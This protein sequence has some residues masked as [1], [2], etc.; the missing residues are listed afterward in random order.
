MGVRDWDFY[1]DQVSSIYD[2]SGKT[3]TNTK[4]HAKTNTH[5]HIKIGWEYPYSVGGLFSDIN[6]GMTKPNGQKDFS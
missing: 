1:S 3:K 6:G 5:S 2:S 4:T